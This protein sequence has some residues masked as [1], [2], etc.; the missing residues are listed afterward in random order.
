MRNET[1]IRPMKKT[2]NLT[3]NQDSS[4]S[5]K[6]FEHLIKYQKIYLTIVLLLVLIGPL[7]VKFFTPENVQF[8]GAESYYHL[9]SA[10][11]ISWN[12]FYYYPLHLLDKYFSSEELTV[13]PIILALICLF[14]IM[15]LTKKLELS[16]KITFIF[17]LLTILSPAFI[18]TFSTL[19]QYSYYFVL[20]LVMLI[21]LKQPNPFFRAVAILP[22]IIATFFDSFST[23]ILIVTLLI[24]VQ[25]I[26]K[27]NRTIVWVITGISVALLFINK[28]VLNFT[29]FLGPFHPQKIIPDLISDF[30]G[31][32]GVSFF[33]LLLAIIGL[34]VTWKKKNFYVAYLFLPLLIPAFFYTTQTIFLF[35]LALSFFATVG[36]TKISQIP[37]NFS[38]LK[39]F[40]ALLLILGIIFSTI[41]FIDRSAT[42]TISPEEFKTLLWIKENT[43]EKAII[44]SAPENGPYITYF[45]ERMPF[46]SLSDQDQLKVSLSHSALNSLYIHE[47]FP[48]L[49]NNKISHL[50]ITPKMKRD[51]PKDI[52]LMFLLKNERFKLIH[53]AEDTEVWVFN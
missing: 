1:S 3:N 46:Y 42:E 20:L 51:L 7:S 52:G 11:D 10:Q 45:S 30:G 36:L 8:A 31:I 9:S 21:L 22:A 53:S 35:T 2:K 16:P 4:E 50:Y 6:Y 39:K 43:P 26:K 17:I 40:T 44:L 27:E 29:F 33:V 19:S 41:A 25:A 13:V 12:N 5:N 34:S 38:T 18:I 15:S 47:L 14:L 32:S 24:Y 49:E 28:I 37:W 23:L 48:I